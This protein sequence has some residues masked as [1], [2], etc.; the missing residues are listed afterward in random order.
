M[1]KLNDALRL[2]IFFGVACVLY[3]YV[4]GVIGASVVKINVLEKL[5]E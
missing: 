5:M 2:I 1:K 3:L 4:G